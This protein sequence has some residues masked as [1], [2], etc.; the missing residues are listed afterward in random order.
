VRDERP[1]NAQN[2]REHDKSAHG[3]RHAQAPLPRA[4]TLGTQGTPG[5]GALLLLLVRELHERVGYSALAL[6]ALPMLSAI[7]TNSEGM[8][9]IVVVF[10]SDPTSVIICMRRSSS[11]SGFLVMMRDASAS[12]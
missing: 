4:L 3:D 9:T 10:C 7:V 5:R 8:S 1:A 6:N 12:F 11:A 2:S